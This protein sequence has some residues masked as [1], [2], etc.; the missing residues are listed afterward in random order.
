MPTQRCAALVMLLVAVVFAPSAARAHGMRAAIVE[1]TEQPGG[2]ALVRFEI[3]DERS[4]AEPVLAG[5]D[6]VPVDPGS[7][8]RV[9]HCPDGLDGATL[10]VHGLG[11]S[12][13]EAV[14]RVRRTDGRVQQGVL[15]AA[16]P[17]MT[18]REVQTGLDVAHVHVALGF[19]HIL[20]GLDHLLFLLL[21][22]L[23]AREL[24][25]VLIAETAFAL[26]HALTFSATSLGWIHVASAPA[27]ACIALSLVLL[28][29][30]VGRPGPRPSAPG[31]AALAFGFGAI[32]GLGFAGG[33]RELGTPDAHAAWALIGFGLGVEIGQLLFVVVAMALFALLRRTRDLGATEVVAACAAGG[34]ATFW[35]LQRGMA[36]FGL[37]VSS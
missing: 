17:A 19:A 4:W 30:D 26:S 27:E 34:L 20:A 7:R 5:C 1:V 29:L 24:R 37:E 28:A 22:V 21:L 11:A 36:C 23:Y 10:T 8:A 25:A 15:T 12:I 32:H 13:S 18:I 6:L 14:V 3:T 16:A 31:L 9:A 35:L 33:L 2:D